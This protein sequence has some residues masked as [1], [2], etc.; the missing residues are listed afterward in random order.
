MAGLTALP[1]DC[2]PIQPDETLDESRAFI[3]LPLFFASSFSRHYHPPHIILVLVL[4]M[5]V[6]NEYVALQSCS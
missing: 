3:L 1:R 6:C 5:A 4:L 2:L